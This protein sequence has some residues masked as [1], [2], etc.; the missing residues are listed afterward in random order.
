MRRLSPF[1]LTAVLVLLSIGLLTAFRS[2][3]ISKLGEL[4]WRERCAATCG[5][6]ADTAEKS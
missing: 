2:G 3:L 4:D 5:G 6:S 1:L